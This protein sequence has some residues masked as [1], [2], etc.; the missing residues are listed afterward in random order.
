MTFKREM[1]IG[2]AAT[3]LLIG[4][5]GLTSAQAGGFGVREQSAYYQGMSFAGAATGQTLGSMAW[6]SAAAAAVSGFNTESSYSLVIPD[7]EITATGGLLK[8]NAG[9]FGISGNES[10]NVGQLALVP[11]S[12]ANYQLNDRLFLGLAVYSPFGF[13]TKPDNRDWVGSPIGA[14]SKVFDVNFNPTVAYKL[15][16]ELTVGVG[17]QVEYFN[18]RLNSGNINNFPAAG[19]NLSGRETKG[20]DWGLGYTAGVTWKATPGTIIGVGYRSEVDFN[21]EGNCHGR[22][23]STFSGQ[24]GATNIP[25]SLALCNGDIKADI[26]LPQMVTASISQRLSQQWTVLGTVEWTDWSVIQSPS[27]VNNAG[28]KVDS[29]PLN[30]KDGWFYSLGAEYAYSPA[31]TLRGGAAWERSPISDRN[32]SVLLPDADRIWA[33]GGLTYKYSSNIS[34][35]LAYSHLF[36]QDGNIKT[37]SGSTTLLTATSETSIDIVSAGVK[38]HVGGPRE[39]LEPLK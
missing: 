10:G 29:L 32:R 1:K 27:I 38:Y 30:Y 15:T 20:D 17:V 13:T 24:G 22:S 9:A 23:L 8:N 16:P 26:T 34:F 4:F 28:A 6:N 21:L 7:S 19:V 3:A 2:V 37:A 39:Q 12:F 35:D 31:L 25:A 11:A 36:Y 14:T 18:I 33:S 5:A